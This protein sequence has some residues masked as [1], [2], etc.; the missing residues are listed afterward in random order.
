MTIE[1]LKSSQTYRKLF[2]AIIV[3]QSLIILV[4]KIVEY[5][6]TN[7]GVLEHQLPRAVFWIYFWIGI[8][9]PIISLVILVL[10]FVIPYIRKNLIEESGWG[11]WRQSAALCFLNIVA[12]IPWFYFGGLVFYSAGGNR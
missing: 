9:A 11:E 4:S 12:A 2:I 7:A 8:S 10:G 5:S 3:L 1:F 6:N